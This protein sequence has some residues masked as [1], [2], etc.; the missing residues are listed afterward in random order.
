MGLDQVLQE[1]LEYHR[2]VCDSAPCACAWNAWDT[3]VRH[4]DPDDT[5]VRLGISYDGNIEL[6][7]P[8]YREAERVALMRRIEKI[9]APRG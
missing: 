5:L 4:L 1:E 2:D 3:I 8:E 9:E 7:S 6:Q